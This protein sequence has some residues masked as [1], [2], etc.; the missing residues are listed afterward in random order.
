[1]SYVVRAN[2][3]L[4]KT[5]AWRVNQP[6]ISE[7][8]QRRRTIPT[9]RAEISWLEDGQPLTR[10]AV[11]PALPLFQDALSAFA[12]GT[13][14]QTP[15]G[16][17]AVEDLQPG[18]KV[19]TAEGPAHPIRWIGSMTVLPNSPELN[20]PEL[21]LF[22]VTDGGYGL[23]R[24]A[25]DLLLGPAARILPGILATN[26]SSP[27]RNIADMADGS[28]V[29]EIKPMSPVR[30]FHIALDAHRLLR[31]N[32]LLAESYH[33]GANSRLYVSREMYEIFL[34][35]FPHLDNEGGFG[36]Q[37]HQRGSEAA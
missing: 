16:K 2:T 19:S 9:R 25:P 33:P 15:D 21:K 24:S 6:E 31:A 18:M 34:K 3:A 37:A 30:V 29:I 13:L 28:S 20:L 4:P 11:V 27:L 1:M 10:N 22:R 14:I 26:S 36:I 17:V 32:G 23:E 7:E 8:E 12:Q 5:K 35:L